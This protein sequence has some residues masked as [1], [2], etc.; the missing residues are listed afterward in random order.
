MNIF[1]FILVDSKVRSRR[2]VRFRTNF[3]FF[4]LSLQKIQIFAARR[5]KLK[6]T[7]ILSSGSVQPMMILD[8]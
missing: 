5:M 3:N 1:Y 2:R 7:R 6:Q 4:M 8:D